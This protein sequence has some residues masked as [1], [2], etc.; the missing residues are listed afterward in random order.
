MHQKTV[1]DN[2][3]RIVSSTMPHTYSVCICIF[4]EA[5]S[6][7]EFSGQE[8]LAHFVEHL[9]FKGTETRPTSKEISQ[10]IDGIGGILNG[11][12]DKELT[13]YWV[14]VA[15]P[16]FSFALDVL[17][18]MIRN[19]RFNPS[20]IETE[21]KI[22]IEELNMCLD[23]PH[24]R[25]D[26][27]IDEV[28]WPDQPLGHDIAGNKE[29]VSV[30]DRQ[31]VID[32]VSNHYIPDSTVISVAGDISHDEVVNSVI[33]ALGDWGRGSAAP[34]LPADNRQVTPRLLAEQR[35]TE[36]VHLCLA[37]R[38]IPQMHP[39]RYVLSLLNL[40]LGGSMSSRLF[41]EL[42]ERM[43]LAY[44]IH[45]QITYF[46][47]AGS[48]NIYAGVEPERTEDTIKAILGEL[49]KLRDIQVPELE[50]TRAKV[51]SNG[52][53]M[54]RM[55]DTRGVAGWLGS[56]ELLMGYVRSVD[57]VVGVINAITARDLQRVAS[58][59]FVTN[60]LNLVL[61]GPIRNKD[62]FEEYLQL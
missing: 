10:A 14:K 22:I 11:E 29:T 53:L 36:Q 27:L 41:L 24:E 5:G 13:G 18:D 47:D 1:L 16:H 54:L 35:D 33:A 62:R 52:R 46:R 28:I 61:V 44:D 19:S 55:E 48:I 31:M 3:L 12:T 32:Y 39:D 8:G 21:R 6:R 20:D 34:W 7:H 50:I 49:V 37:M 38:G 40:I 60:G 2:G 30:I 57:E 56:Q 9:C 45:S 42:R 58:E 26:M 4:I 25:V 23:S 43:G 59:L 15:R 51:L 17:V